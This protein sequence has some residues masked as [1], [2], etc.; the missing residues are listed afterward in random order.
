MPSLHDAVVVLDGVLVLRCTF[1]DTP[2][3]TSGSLAS[4]GR[5]LYLP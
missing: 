3:L 5:C 1:P 4:L 2:H